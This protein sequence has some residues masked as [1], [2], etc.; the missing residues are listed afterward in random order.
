MAARYNS[1]ES[2]IENEGDVRDLT[3]HIESMQPYS[4]EPKWEGQD[5]PSEPDSTDS[6]ESHSEENEEE[7]T[8]RLGNSNWC[9][10]GKC[11]HILLINVM[12]HV[13]C[14]EKCSTARKATLNDKGRQ[15]KIILCKIE[16]IHFYER[17]LLL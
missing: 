1:E 16:F 8:D 17:K 4:F 7:N 6:E 12:E 10:C 14:K 9:K 2:D 13:C 11:G 5:K 15:T 3:D